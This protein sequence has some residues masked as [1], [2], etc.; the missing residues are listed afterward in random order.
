MMIQT[1]KTKLGFR[2]KVV[3]FNDHIQ[4]FLIT[5]IRLF[6]VGAAVWMFINNHPGQALII[7]VL[8]LTTYIA[9][10]FF[11]RRLG[12]MLPIEF[13]CVITV[14]LFSCIYIGTISGAYWY[15]P[16]WDNA[17]HAISGVVFGFLGFLVLY[18]AYEQ[19]R[20]QMSLKIMAMFAFCFS[21]ACGAVWEIAEFSSDSLLGSIAQRNNTD[22]MEDLLYDA[23][24]ALLIAIAGYRYIKFGRGYLHRFVQNFRH[25]NPHLFAKATVKSRQRPS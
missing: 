10:L 22:T 25:H 11:E 12:L 19:K 8:L 9:H 2:R 17:M 13:H 5:S 16:W 23:L 15:V 20:L 3:T 21:M 4:R 7:L 24:G 1:I 6:L 18:T 14:F